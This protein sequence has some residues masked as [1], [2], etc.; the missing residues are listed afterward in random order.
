M[1]TFKQI[2][3]EARAP[4]KPKGPPKT[5]KNDYG[6]VATAKNERGLDYG[7]I[8]VR[9]KIKPEERKMFDERLKS[10]MMKYISKMGPMSPESHVGA[11][12]GSNGHVSFFEHGKVSHGAAREHTVAKDDKDAIPVVVKTVHGK[13]TVHR[14]GSQPL[15]PQMRDSIPNHEGLIRAFGT[16]FT[17]AED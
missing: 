12:L 6:D 15:T 14:A 4:A 3:A 8:H 9:D 5:P 11:W 2:L 7:I 17:V 13:T 1:K 10:H 16:K